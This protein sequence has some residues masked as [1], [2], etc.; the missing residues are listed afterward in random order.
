M[1]RSASPAALAHVGKPLVSSSRAQADSGC[2][3]AFAWA[4][5]VRRCRMTAVA[6]E[7]AVVPIIQEESSHAAMSRWVAAGLS[8]LQPADP[9]HD[10]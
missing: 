7:T 1:A 6:E 9:Q 5:P 10:S 8:P 2:W 3:G 4:G